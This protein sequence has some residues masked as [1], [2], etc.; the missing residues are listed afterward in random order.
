VQF[1]HRLGIDSPLSPNLSIALGATNTTL[2]EL[3]SAFSVFP[4]GGLHIHPFGIA[5]ILGRDNAVRWRARP[6]IRSVMTD[7]QA[8]IMV[9]MLQGTVLEGTGK[10]ARRLNMP[11]AGKTGTTNDFRDALF[12]GFSPAIATGVWV[13][14]DDF[15][16]LG[17]METGARA[18]LPTWI[19]FMASTK[20]EST[21]L[22][23]D[24]PDNMIKIW[25]DPETG[26]AVEEGAQN[27]VKA[28]FVRGTEPAG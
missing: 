6:A 28:L 3:T 15:T 19:N 4:G 23:F 11:V 2:L 17:D 20:P 13:G 1:A 8:A 14:M 25:M 22:Y 5:E 9:D 7:T 26:R 12:V 24:I 16:P 10:Q 21:A 27:A 18:A